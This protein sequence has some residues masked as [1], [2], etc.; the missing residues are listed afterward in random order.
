MS[1]Q[2][3]QPGI[4]APLA[5][6]GRSLAFRLKPDA[7]LQASLCRLRD[8]FDP[9]WGVLGFG[10]PLTRALSSEIL[11][12]RAF[13]ALAGPGCSV[14]STQQAAWV[15]LRGEDRGMLFD[16]SERVLKM[17][18]G[19]LE[20]DD[21]TDTFRYGAGRDLTGYEDGTENP[22]GDEARNAA[23]AGG[24]GPLAE[25]SFAAVQRW[26]HDLR[27]FRS[28]PPERRDHI[29]GRRAS[30]NEELDSAPETAHV[31][32]TA[33]ESFEPA[34]FMVRRSMPWAT[35]HQQ[36]LEFIAYTRSLD[37]FDTMLSR[38]AGLEDGIVDALFTFSRP[39]TGG[40]YW[41]PLVKD[42]SLHLRALGL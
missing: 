23:C 27:Q 8:G 38:M 10:L 28:F 24:E 34:A 1:L 41:C 19:S 40:Y 11:G 13:P 20:L 2:I 29:I 35:A 37:S 31:K 7:P 6:V 21:A 12:L 39:L 15:M 18:E 42:G 36:G 9:D 33:Q 3:C 14:P 26:A 32:R 4:L 16:H 17:L 30:D 5:A 25:S 22:H